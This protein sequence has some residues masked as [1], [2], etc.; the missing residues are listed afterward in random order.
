MLI[1][2]HSLHVEMHGNST[3]P[4]VIFLHH[5]L[6]SVRAW[7]AQLAN[8]AAAGF[9]TVAFDRWG[10]GKSDPRPQ[11]NMPFFPEDL[12]DLHALVKA[13][14]VEQV[15]LVGHSDGG[16]IALYFA[17]AHPEIVT[18]LVTVAAH[19]HVEAKMVPG[20][21]VISNSYYHDADFQGKF[22]RQHGNQAEAVFNNWFNGWNRAE[23]LS[24][25][26]RP[27]IRQITCPT[28]V[29]QGVEDE[30]SSPQHARQIAAAIPGAELWLVPGVGHMLPQEYAREFNQRL[31]DF[32]R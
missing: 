7:K 21:A 31:I 14:G 30:Y 16:T 25:D 15:S 12:E 13:I 22:Q 6:G 18:H 2:G 4:A 23:N 5:G 28:L 17:A 27:L 8:L 10:Y 32:L 11:F 1:N 19:V 20:L 3:D 26:M 9:H 24:W 29:V